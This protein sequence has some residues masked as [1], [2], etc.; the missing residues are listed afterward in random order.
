MKKILLAAVIAMNLFAVDMTTDNSLDSDDSMSSTLSNKKDM[1]ISNSKSKDVSK[2]KSKSKNLTSSKDLKYDG[3]L[4]AIRQIVDF[5]NNGVY[6]FSSCKLLTKPLQPSDFGFVCKTGAFLNTG[7]CSFLSE[8]A[9]NYAR[10]NDVIRSSDIKDFKGYLNCGVYYGAVIAQFLKTNEID[11]EI[12]DS[13]IKKALYQAELDINK[14]DCSFNGDATK[15]LCGGVSANIGDML[16]ISQY[17][18]KLY[19]DGVF[20]G[21]NLSVGNS[22]S[23]SQAIS[24]DVRMSRSRS[25][26]NNMSK[27]LDMSDSTANK[28]SQKATS[29]MSVGKFID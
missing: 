5:E 2:T 13:V 11:F 23:L 12:T 26:G 10:L 1:S 19:S 24:D 29:S 28:V 3:A 15:V 14:E 9:K 17:N 7:K 21:Y 16:T 22:K 20:Y 4:D 6:P 27:S 18:A 25:K 8:S